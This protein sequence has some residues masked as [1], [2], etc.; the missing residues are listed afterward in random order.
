VSSLKRVFSV[1]YGIVTIV[2]LLSVIQVAVDFLGNHRAVQKPLED[3]KRPGFCIFV[4]LEDNTLYLLQDNVCIKKYRI[5]SGKRGWPSPIGFWK[6]VNKSDWGEGFGGRWMGFDVPWGRYGIH[7]TME[8][9][10]VGYYASHGC[11]RMYNRDVRELYNIVPVG[12]PVTVVDGSFGP[13]GTGFKN[14]ETGDR[15]ADV[16]AVQRRLKDLDFFKGQI[17]GIYE[18]DLKV[19]VH[20]FQRASG[21]QVKNT[22]S[23]EDYEAMG[24]REFE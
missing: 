14:L 2:F 4:E 10:S 17:S 5:A 22:I 6:I 21:L 19:A 20:K 15:G 3:G 18:D 11:I 7:G 23:R 24:F 12:T 9:S 13:F 16:I 1:F 8:E